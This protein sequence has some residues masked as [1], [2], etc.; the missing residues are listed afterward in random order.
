M[1]VYRTLK[2]SVSCSPL[3][4]FKQVVLVNIVW[5]PCVQNDSFDPFC[6]CN[7]VVPQPLEHRKPAVAISYGA[8]WSYPEG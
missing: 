6:T 5:M 2:S 1:S 3:L 4:H 7:A 8:V